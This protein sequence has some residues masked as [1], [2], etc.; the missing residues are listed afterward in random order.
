[1]HFTGRKGPFELI[2]TASDHGKRKPCFA[3]SVEPE[4]KILSA[5]ISCG[6][7]QFG[8][9]NLDLEQNLARAEE[10]LTG[11]IKEVLFD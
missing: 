10:F 5:T 1:M 3:G 8:N 6:I 7:H 4:E 11:K 2:R 9:P